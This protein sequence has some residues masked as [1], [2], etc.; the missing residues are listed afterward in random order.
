LI[1]KL[2]ISNGKYHLGERAVFVPSETFGVFYYFQISKTGRARL[3]EE[4]Y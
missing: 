1:G 3:D 4:N 2:Q